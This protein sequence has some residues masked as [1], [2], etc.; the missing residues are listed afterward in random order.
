[1]IRLSAL[2]LALMVFVGQFQKIYANAGGP[3]QEKVETLGRFVPPP[4]ACDPFT[5]GKLRLSDDPETL[6]RDTFVTGCR[7][8]K[9]PFKVLSWCGQ[10]V[11]GCLRFVFFDRPKKIIYVLTEHVEAPY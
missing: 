9:A 5:T 4:E 8:L 1:M 3:P 11:W 7:Y 2:V 6:P 10:A